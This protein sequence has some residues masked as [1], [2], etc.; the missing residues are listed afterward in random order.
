[1]SSS[2]SN[3]DC[4][5]N[6]VKSVKSDHFSYDF[7]SLQCSC[8]FMCESVKRCMAEFKTFKAHSDAVDELRQLLSAQSTSVSSIAQRLKVQGKDSP[9]VELQ[10]IKDLANGWL[11]EFRE[12]KAEAEVKG[13]CSDF[14][15]LEML[16]DDEEH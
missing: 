7:T 2:I 9:E 3:P 5:S 12:M 14:T 8:E 4:S 16:A 11:E 6:H 10:K 15:Y 1:M 13:I